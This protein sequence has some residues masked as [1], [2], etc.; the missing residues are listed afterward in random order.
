MMVEDNLTIW[1]LVFYIPYMKEQYVYNPICALLKYL[2]PHDCT[3]NEHEN[4]FRRWLVKDDAIESQYKHSL[5]FKF[6]ILASY[7]Q[8]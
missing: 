2:Q 7:F 4:N 6:P 3:F 5:C 1:F 8:L